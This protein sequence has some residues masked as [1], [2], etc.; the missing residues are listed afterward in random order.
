MGILIIRTNMKQLLEQGYYNL[1]HDLN[2]LIF[3]V[4]MRFNFGKNIYD[5]H[6]HV[7][8]KHESTRVKCVGWAYNNY[9]K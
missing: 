3:D 9:C 8:N 7:Q 2:T 1:N 5:T 6:P 4:N